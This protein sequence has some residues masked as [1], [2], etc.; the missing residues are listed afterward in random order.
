[1]GNNTAGKNS[2]SYVNGSQGPAQ[3]A[4]SHAADASEHSEDTSAEPV[5]QDAEATEA[6]APTDAAADT[7]S[8]EVVL[9]RAQLAQ[10]DARLQATLSQYKEALEEFAGAKA[11]LHRDVGKEIEAGKRAMLSSLLEVV[12]NLERA[13]EAAAGDAKDNASSFFT[14]ITMV[15]DQFQQKLTGMG[16]TKLAAAGETFDPA[17]FEAISTVPVTDPAQDGKVLGVV[18]DCYLLGQ[19]TLRYGMVAVGKLSES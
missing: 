3:G 1:M 8:S 17:H 19:E 14:G 7:A 10:K 9:L 6:D 12:D 16:V 11:R 5:L 13:L 4:K 18:R 15:R 2:K